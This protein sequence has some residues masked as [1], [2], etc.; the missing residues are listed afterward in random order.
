[1]Y[2]IN[3]I[4]AFPQKYC[5]LQC[6]KKNKMIFLRYSYLCTEGKIKRIKEWLKVN[7]AC[8]CFV[9]KQCFFTENISHQSYTVSLATSRNSLKRKLKKG[10]F[11]EPHTTSL[12]KI[13]F[14][15]LTPN[16]HSRTARYHSFSGWFLK[17]SSI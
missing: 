14:H 13:Y 7:P 5:N 8:F 1:M 17:G 3:C 9:F 15:W 4:S 16:L 6:S 10:Y 12:N 2:W 11:A